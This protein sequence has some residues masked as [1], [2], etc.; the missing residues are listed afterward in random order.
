MFTE[1]LKATGWYDKLNQPLTYD[2]NKVG[3]HIT[4]LAQT[5]DVSMRAGSGPIYTAEEIREA[6]GFEGSIPDIDLGGEE[7]VE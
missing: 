4:V 7:V 3:S 2:A 6:G 1:V 5:N